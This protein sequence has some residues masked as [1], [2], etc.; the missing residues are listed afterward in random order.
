VASLPA[1]E[2]VFFLAGLKFGSEARPDRT[3]F[4]N[5]VPPA[6]VA[7]RYASARFVV[8]STGNV[9]PALPA[10]STGSVEAD[11]PAPLG[12]Y[13][14][15]CLA[16]ERIFEYFSREKGTPC[17]FFRLNYAVDLRYGVLVDI[18]R[19]V[20]AKEP[21]DLRV[22]RANAIWQGDALSYAVRCL[23]LATAPPRILNVTGP[24]FSVREAAEFFAVRFGS[25]PHFSGP[26]GP[27]ALLSNPSLC[28]SLLGPPAVSHGQLLGLVA[29]WLAAGGRTLEK[30]TAFERTDG[31]Y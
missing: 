22:P 21:V 2:N 9:Y 1:V 12:E 4:T 6:L 19:K 10:S 16:R 3:W 25:P 26:E 31:R 28:Q 18:A 14:Q 7:Q 24:L 30:P 11:A 15:S 23:G 17:V 13:A 27:R 20:R 29:D 8:F 5:T